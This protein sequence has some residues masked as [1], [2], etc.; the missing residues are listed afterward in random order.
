MSAFP[1]T[2]PNV[3]SQGPS[4]ARKADSTQWTA[5]I[6]R[7]LYPKQGEPEREDGFTI[8]LGRHPDTGELIKLKGSFGPVTNGDTIDITRGRWADDPNNAWGETEFMWVDAI[9]PG[10]PETREAV[11]RYLTQLRGTAAKY[12][13][14]IVDSLGAGCLR[15]IDDDPSVLLT[16][17][18][19]FGKKIDPG[20]AWELA[21]DWPELAADRINMLFLAR[22]GITGSRAKA[23]SQHFGKQCSEVLSEN[24]YEMVVVRGVNFRV[25]DRAA[26][27]M[28]FRANDLRR[29]GAGA[30]FVL[31][32]AEGEGHVCLTH[33]QII[34]RALETLFRPGAPRPDRQL[35][36]D[37]IDRMVEEGRLW[38]VCEDSDNVERVYTT[39]FFVIETRLYERIEAL[40]T[41]P[42]AE[43][44]RTWHMRQRSTLTD[45]QWGAVEKVMKFKLSVLTGGPGTGKTTT[46][47]TIL[48]ELDAQRQSYTC[49]APTGKAAKRMEESTG[50]PAATVHRTLG[51]AA[52]EPPRS[53]EEGRVDDAKVITSDVVIVDESSMTDLRLFERLVSHMG[54]DTR[55]LLVGDP[56]QLPAVGAGS[57]LHDLLESG[58]VPTTEL[59]QVHRQAAGSLLVLNANRI[60][61]GKDPYW[62][63]EEAED[64]LRREA[65]ERGN[66]LPDDFSVADDWYFVEAKD[67]EQARR[68]TLKLV[69]RIQI[70]LGVPVDEV[71][72]T[73]PQRF[74]QTGVIALNKDL[75]SRWNAHGEVV[76]GGDQPLRRGDRVMN[77]RNRYGSTRNGQ[78]IEPDI[79]NGE[80]GK[81]VKFN[82]ATGSVGVDFGVGEIINFTKSQ[83]DALIPAYCSTTHKLQGSEAPAIVAPLMDAESRV[84]SRQ[85]VYTGWT[86]AQQLCCVVGTKAALRGAIAKDG[87]QRNTRLDLMVSRVG[88]RIRARWE[89]MEAR[90]QTWAQRARRRGATLPLRPYSRFLS[91]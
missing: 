67:A 63:R 84:V 36:L 17:R 66:P 73:A 19:R 41:A 72:V 82:S 28:K 54:A 21:L 23:I 8:A 15:T 47:R 65:L 1:S 24:P 37:A 90:Q 71:L 6:E 59:T 58:R 32:E 52:L 88:P 39:E 81:I 50:R 76:R 89:F 87:S 44:P 77:T 33:E 49:L 68:K 7:K 51:G 53:R 61:D 56:H 20:E 78:Q 74:G 10:I 48:D 60:K 34:G 64:D 83:L 11:I 85:L 25:A 35:I 46:L 42:A 14:A 27:Q 2:A 86:R 13:T 22:I 45:E 30:E 91:S 70:K 80:I 16:V 9:A 62:T 38:A 18:S 26:A 31:Q 55:L 75:Q 29:L 4:A 3:R 5:T 79:M 69:E 12:A 57:V 43:P 40:L